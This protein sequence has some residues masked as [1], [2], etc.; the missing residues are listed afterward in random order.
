MVEEFDDSV[1]V[2]VPENTVFRRINFIALPY[3]G[4][5]TD[6]QPQLV[7]FL[8]TVSGTSSA[9]EGVWNE[10]FRYVGE[11]E[12]M[13]ANIRVEG[14]LAIINGVEKLMGA[15]VRATD[16]RAGAAMIIAGLMADG[17]TV[18]S[19]ISHIDRG[20]ENFEEK[21]IRL[22]GDIHRITVVEEF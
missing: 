9:R 2:Y 18:I 16:L 19:D 6:M 20:Y 5:P 8:S 21:F 10:R 22:G 1:R 17:T 14:K 11:L 7:A 12:R 15:Q 3:P 13:G 4:Y